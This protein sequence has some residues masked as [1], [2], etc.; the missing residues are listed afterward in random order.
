MKRGGKEEPSIHAELLLSSDVKSLSILSRVSR[1]NL[2]RF[3]K[4]T[5]VK[6]KIK[7]IQTGA[8]LEKYY[9]C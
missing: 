2:M 1:N 5:N 3:E 4:L 9:F 6:L 8:S 7:S